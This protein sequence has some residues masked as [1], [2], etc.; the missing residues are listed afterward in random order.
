MHR[1]VMLFG[2][3]GLLAACVSEVQLDIDEDEDGL[4]ASEEAALG[5]DPKN[6]D[7]DG[8]GHF[9]GD[10]LDAGFDPADSEDHPYMGGYDISRCEDYENGTGYAVGEISP[11]FELED[12]HGE[13]VALSDFCGKTILIEGSAD[14]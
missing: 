9:D 3:A 4:L 13:M 1:F 7:S 2:M 12:Q 14:W 8:D 6:P 10:E 11:D 5:T